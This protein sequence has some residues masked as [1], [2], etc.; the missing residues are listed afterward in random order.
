MEPASVPLMHFCVFVDSKCSQKDYPDF[1]AHLM[2]CLWVQH[3]G[4]FQRNSYLGDGEG[5]GF[6]SYLS[7][8]LWFLCHHVKI[9]LP[10]SA[11][12]RNPQI[13]LE[14]WKGRE[15]LGCFSLLFWANGYASI[16]IRG[17]LIWKY[18]PPAK[19]FTET[20]RQ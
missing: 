10:G 2:T 4:Y 17:L 3:S 7:I 9:R 18:Y 5:N 14:K 16:V 20:L 6:G 13:Y 15:D 12:S 8:G 19:L 11:Y 1:R